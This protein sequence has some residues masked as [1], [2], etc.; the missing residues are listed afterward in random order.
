[1]IQ[2]AVIGAGL[3]GRGIA[4]VV[5]RAGFPV[6]LCD[7]NAETLAQA[8]E[9]VRGTVSTARERVRTE[10]VL[11]QA[12]RSAEIVIEAVLEDLLVKRELFARLGTANPDAIL[13]SNSSVLPITQI[14]MLTARPERAV[15]THW[16]NPPQLIPVVE[17]IRGRRT[18]EK[19]MQRTVE[20]L[21]ALGK[22]PVRVERD[23]PGFVGNRLQHALW[24]E[25]LVLVSDGVCPP[26]TVDRIVA[27]TLG[28]SL[29]ERG[30]IVEMRR[31]GLREVTRE[32]TD[33][34]PLVS[35]DPRPARLLRELV[36]AG[37]LGAKTGRGFLRWP[38]GAQALAGERL[39]GHLERRL[40]RRAEEIVPASQE[41][42]EADRDIARRLRV[43]L[44][45]EALALVEGGVC[46]AETVDLMAMSTLGLRLPAM[47]PVVNA[48]YVGLDLTLAIHEVVLPALEAGVSVPENL[49]NI[50]AAA[51]PQSMAATGGPPFNRAI[52]SPP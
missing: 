48:D 7:A 25:A 30:P 13:M 36:A 43:A 19:T 1:M 37:H 22:N 41:L 28:A 4:E 5:S 42:S 8:C 32:L 47:G 2:V 39:R 45:R 27:A 50:L 21:K 35:S 3:L 20:F 15:G 26:E 34:L 44:W 6:I 29:A 52:P 10:S 31:T 38:P 12:A 11:E 46:G 49:A 9:V 24:R 17:V 18:T 51:A 14:A 16:W 23:L 40:G 33:M